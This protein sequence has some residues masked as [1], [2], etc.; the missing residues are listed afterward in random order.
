MIRRRRHNVCYHEGVALAL[1]CCLLLG[2]AGCRGSHCAVD[3]PER[4]I[5]APTALAAD[6]RERVTRVLAE[7]GGAT[8][9]VREEEVT[10]ILRQALGGSPLSD[11]ALHVTEQ[12]LYLRLAVGRQPIRAALVPVVA[13]GRLAIR[14]SCLAVGKSTLPRIAGAAV[15]SA[16]T[17][18][19]TDAAWS[20]RVESVTLR[21]GAIVV[22]AE[23]RD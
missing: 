21:E 7:P 22:V 12:A 4:A 14:V 10:A 15:E 6:L 11:V 17:A 9:S 3:A 19:A 16:V 5:D 8:L 13:D 23:R 18:L 1:A 2:I 20:L